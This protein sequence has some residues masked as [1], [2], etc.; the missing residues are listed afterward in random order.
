[1]LYIESIDD[2][3]M[4]LNGNAVAQTG[5]KV[6]SKKDFLARA[7]EPVY[8]EVQ[9]RVTVYNTNKDEKLVSCKLVSEITLDGTVYATAQEFVVTFN[10]LMNLC[11][12]GEV[13]GGT[14][15]ATTIE[16]VT[17]TSA[18][19]W[20]Y[21]GVMVAG[22]SN[23]WYGWWNVGGGEI[24]GSITPE[25]VVVNGVEAQDITWNDGTLGTYTDTL[26]NIDIEIN[27]TLYQIDESGLLVCAN[28][29][30]E[31]ETYTIK[32]RATEEITTTV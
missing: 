5:F 4:S 19:S 23:G 32:L 21:E 10:N 13:G 29:F 15:P 1:M 28:P 12:C 18:E 26:Y 30:V 14:T 3:N 16:E 31:G 2:C 17:T 25:P 22:L 6:V 24:L 8:N 27:G 9:G 11:C 7:N 20:D